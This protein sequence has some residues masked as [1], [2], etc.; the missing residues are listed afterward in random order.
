MQ[1]YELE[2]LKYKMIFFNVDQL[3]KVTEKGFDLVEI[4][5]DTWEKIKEI[6]SLLKNNS[7][8]ENVPGLTN[9]IHD[10]NNNFVS[11]ILDMNLE[12]EKR[13]VI[14][15]EIGKILKEWIK[16]KYEL[17]KTSIYGI[18]SYR[19]G[20]ILEMHKDRVETHHISA[21][22]IV[23]RAGENWPLEFEDH[24][25]NIHQIYAEPGQMI[26]YES[27]VC[28]HGRPSEFKGEYFRNFFL[29]YKFKDYVYKK[30]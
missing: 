7:K 18:R 30:E 17:E 19:N 12:R 21:I 29:H 10:K 11:D 23:D 5:K 8:L 16:E 24:Q 13:D 3:P 14:H 25:K 28:S 6:Y 15:E 1:L 20:A 26:L 2:E 4:P 9:F 27:A 22:I